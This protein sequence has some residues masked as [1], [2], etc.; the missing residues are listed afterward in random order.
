MENLKKYLLSLGI[1]FGLIL[2]FSFLINI[3]NYFELFSLGVYKTVLIF[4]SLLSVCTGA[5]LLGKKTLQ[6]GYLEG[7]KFG[8]ITCFLMFMISYLAF[9][10]GFS[11]NSLIY[12]LILIFSAVTSSMI[13]INKK[14]LDE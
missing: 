9:D 7:L 13:G 10:E 8:I 12:Y 1:T 4:F 14:K 5:F 3:F 11:V 6:K 2:S